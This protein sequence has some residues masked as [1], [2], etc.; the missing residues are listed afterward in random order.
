MLNVRSTTERAIHN[1]L[2]WHQ[3][4]TKN[5]GGVENLAD[6]PNWAALA[7]RRSGRFAMNEHSSTRACVSSG[8]R[9]ATFTG[10]LGPRFG[11]Y[12]PLHTPGPDG[13]AANRGPAF[14]HFG[15]NTSAISLAPVFIPAH[16]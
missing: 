8:T 10:A 1:I 13:S 14:P 11:T 5:K 7:F 9:N 15:H 4:Q 2:L 12:Y 6:L 16:S 3:L